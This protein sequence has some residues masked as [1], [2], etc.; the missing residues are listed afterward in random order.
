MEKK[1][2]LNCLSLASVIACVFLSGV[3][4]S[5]SNEIVVIGDEGVLGPTLRVLDPYN[6]IVA[7][8]RTYNLT[9]VDALAVGDVNGDS[10]NEIVVAGYEG[11]QG[12]YLRVIDPSA[13][14]GYSII[15]NLA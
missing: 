8:A 5:A 2:V 7:S 1:S 3:L 11:V 9:E 13:I 10:D 12:P 15:T 14:P 6:G 4:A